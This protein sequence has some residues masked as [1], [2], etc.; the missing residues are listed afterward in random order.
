MEEERRGTD[1]VLTLNYLIALD[2]Q[3]TYG[4]CIYYIH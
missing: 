1:W 2:G 4:R 3:D